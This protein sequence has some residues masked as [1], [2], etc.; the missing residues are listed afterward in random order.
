MGKLLALTFSLVAIFV[1]YIF[2]RHLINPPSLPTIKSDEYFGA[3]KTRKTDSTIKSFKINVADDVLDDLRDRLNRTNFFAPLTD[4]NDFEYGMNS[5][6]FQKFHSHWMNIYN[7]RKWEKKL[8]EFDQFKTQIDGL[9]VHFLRVKPPKNKYVNVRP[10]LLVHGWPGSVF[11]FYKILPMLV[12][13]KSLNI[14][15]QLAFEVVSPSIPGYGWSEAPKKKGFGP[16]AAARVFA[17]LMERLN[18]NEY[19]CQGGDWGSMITT[20]LAQM[21]PQRVTGLHINM[22]FASPMDYPGIMAQMFAGLVFPSLILSPADQD[23]VYPIGEKFMNLLQESGYMHIQATKPDTVG[24]A[25]NDSPM[26]LAAYIIEKFSTW[27]NGAYKKLPDGGLTRHYSMDELLTNV[28]IYWTT[29]T[30]ASSQRFY[31]EHFRNPETPLY[32]RAPVLVP[33]GI[34]SFPHEI[35]RQPK[36]F[37]SYKFRNITSYTDMARGGHFGAFEE[38]RLLADDIFKF[39][40][41]VERFT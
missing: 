6:Y 3:D 38:P 34:A 27:T 12:D 10:L 40:S 29:G 7:W 37:L 32:E 25:L 14:D 18:F 28:M 9:D 8:N 15:S 30:I 16:I 41:T 1:G 5:D 21:Y 23:K 31:K 17:K 24:F 39:A 22:A 33:T 20:A 11:E 36:N 4:V 13:P 26:G 35:L 19:Y 2:N